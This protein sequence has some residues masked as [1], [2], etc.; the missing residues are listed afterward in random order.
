MPWLAL[1]VY[2]NPAGMN[3][4]IVE[5]NP[6]FRTSVRA[7]LNHKF[8]SL[9]PLE[10]ESLESLGEIAQLGIFDIIIIGLSEKDSEI[11]ETVLKMVMEKNPFS[12]FIVYSSDPDHKQA[13]SLIRIGVKGY[14]P[15]HACLAELATCVWSVFS[16][17]PY[18]SPQ[19]F[20]NLCYSKTEPAFI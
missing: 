15:R 18:L 14:L 8:H 13:R 10:T 12:S 16:G 3:V 7:M 5:K 19:I 1:S 20:V 9:T 2:Q 4:A 11:D 6:V 17:N